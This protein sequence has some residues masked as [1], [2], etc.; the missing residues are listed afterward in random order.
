MKEIIAAL[1][2]NSSFP[3][4]LLKNKTDVIA[5]AAVA[6]IKYIT[7]LPRF[8]LLYFYSHDKLRNPRP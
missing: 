3:L 7:I 1:S 2:P 4:F 8:P 5:T 6:T